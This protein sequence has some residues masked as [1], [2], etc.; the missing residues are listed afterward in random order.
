MF[1][2]G[3]KNGGNIREKLLVAANGAVCC[4]DRIACSWRGYISAEIGCEEPIIGNI[5]KRQ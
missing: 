1:F 3:F 5:V 2:R 4:H